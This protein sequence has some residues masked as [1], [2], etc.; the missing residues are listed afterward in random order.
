MKQIG[1]GV[2][3]W[4]FMG[5]THTHALREMSLF[6]PD[7]DFRP[8]LKCV[9]TRRI[10]QA[11]RAA[12][13]MGFA[14]YTDDYRRL[15]ARDDIDCVSI[16]TPNEQHEEQAL[17]AIAA[18]KNIY[19]D[20]PVATTYAAAKRIR[21]AAAEKGVLAQVVMNHRF[22]PSTIRAKQLVDEGRIGDILSFSC[23]YLHSGSVDPDKPIGWK[24][25]M[26]GGVLLDLGF[27]VL[28]LMTWLTGDPEEVLCATRTLYPTRPTKDGGTESALADDHVSMLLRL[29]NG[30]L[31]TVE[32]SKIA[33]GTEDE[34]A[35]EI[36]GT[37]GAIK[38]NL[39]DPNWLW[40]YDNTLPDV[41]YGGD[42]GFT[43]ISCVARFD[44]PAGSFLPSKNTI[45]W[46]RAHMHCYFSFLDCVS[47]GIPPTPSLDDGARL[48]YLCDALR[49]SDE[50]R[51]WVKL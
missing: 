31:G 40:F 2:I 10:D 29:P 6:Y 14:A 12:E 45:G 49:K 27:H 32:A 50:E 48:Q 46:D 21:D 47:K 51:R 1:I 7:A 20:K 19:L 3:G 43:R 44:T 33:T 38:W 4:G 11:Q 34:I 23:R 16:C 8:V 42:K 24:Q 28:D 30:A 13:E 9:C 26:Q 39:M 41:P 22:W 5:R 18:G 35:F 36:Y 37:K 25:T 17:A 15:L